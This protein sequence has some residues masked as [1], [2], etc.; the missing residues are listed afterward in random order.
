M[1]LQREVALVVEKHFGV[2][3]VAFEF[4]RSVICALAYPSLKFLCS[5]LE[6]RSFVD[7]ACVSRDRAAALWAGMEL[8]D[9][10]AHG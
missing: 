2:A 5:S 9:K 1:C 10:P 3:D 6:V 4:G 8:L 7:L